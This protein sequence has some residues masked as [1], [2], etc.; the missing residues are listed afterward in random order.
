MNI[1]FVRI[2]ADQSSGGGKW[3]GPVDSRTREFCYVAIPESRTMHPGME[4]PYKTLIPDLSKFNVT[5]PE[6]LLRML[7]FI[8]LG[9]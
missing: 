2:G 3:N 1:L 8:C 9:E 6:N 7:V 4:R 5:L